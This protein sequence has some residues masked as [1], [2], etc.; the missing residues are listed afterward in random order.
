MFLTAMDIEEI[1]GTSAAAVSDKPFKFE[2][3]HFKRWQQKMKF[4]LTLEKALTWFSVHNKK[5]LSMW[6]QGRNQLGSLCIIK[7]LL[8]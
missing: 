7:K 5:K 6:A 3:T 1:I 8:V 4:F 2:G